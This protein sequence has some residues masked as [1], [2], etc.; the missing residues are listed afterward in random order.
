MSNDKIDAW[1]AENLIIDNINLLSVTRLETLFGLRA[2]Y[3]KVL[4]IIIIIIYQTMI[5]H[6]SYGIVNISSLAIKRQKSCVS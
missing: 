5:T 2:L 6:I 3:I 4:A 1:H